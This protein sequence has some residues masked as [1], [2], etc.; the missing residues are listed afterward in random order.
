MVNSKST[1]RN[2][3]LIIPGMLLCMIGDYC[4]GI[5]PAGSVET[6]L[7]ASSGWASISDLRIGISNTCGMIGTFFYAIAAY[8]FMKWLIT[9]NQ[10]NTKK[11]DRIFL[12]AFYFSLCV[13]CISFIYFHIAC[14]NLIQH[15]NVLYDMTGNNMEAAENALM[16]MFMVEAVPYVVLFILFDVVATVAWIGLVVRKVLKL[17][18]LWIASAPLLMVVV[19]T[20]IDLLPLPFNGINSGFESLGWMLMFIGGVKHIKKVEAGGVN[21]GT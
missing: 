3:L 17:P 1:I 20:L 4:I 9:E 13:G 19:G 6:G 11:W 15:Y 16:R 10:D 21:N 12:T 7:L 5:E 14:G 2:M 18:M 8:S